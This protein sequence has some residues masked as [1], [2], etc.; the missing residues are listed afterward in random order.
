[1]RKPLTPLKYALWLLER[2]DYSIREIRTKFARKEFPEVE[3]EAAIKK[4]IDLKFLDDDRFTVRF[5]EN[6]QARGNVGNRMIYMKLIKKGIDKE[7]IKKYL[8]TADPESLRET[9]VKWLNKH[10]KRETTN[11]KSKLFSYLA[12]RG[13]EYGEIIGALDDE[14]VKALLLDQKR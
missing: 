3:A 6:Q 8:N 10:S 11:I 2:R 14:A 5:I 9:A 7:I 1:M 13:F 4:L 12:G